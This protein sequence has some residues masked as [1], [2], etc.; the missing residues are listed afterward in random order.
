MAQ[1]ESRLRRLIVDELQ[2][3][4]V[5]LAKNGDEVLELAIGMDLE[6]IV[7]DVD[8]APYGGIE[9]C[10]RMRRIEALADVP[11]A[12]TTVR[13]NEAWMSDAMEAGAPAAMS[14]F[15]MTGSRVEN[16][17]GRGAQMIDF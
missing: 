10:R 4:R 17:K 13:T 8:L 3:C 16:R 15:E 11:I 12:I 1:T 14:S 5:L 6:A 2:D 9:V 7:L